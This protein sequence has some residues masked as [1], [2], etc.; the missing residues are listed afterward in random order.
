MKN[1][2]YILSDAKS[3]GK[4]LVALGLLEHL[5]KHAQR[6]I[7]F[8]PISKKKD[9]LTE[10]LQSYFSFDEADEALYG[11]VLDE[12]LPLLQQG[13][14]RELYALIFDKF[15][16]LEARYDHIIIIGTD[17][18]F[19]T[20][21]L[22]F[23]LNAALAN[24]LNAS[25]LALLN[26]FELEI[27]ALKERQRALL[28][29]L[30]AQHCS[31]KGV[32]INQIDESHIEAYQQAFNL[33]A[34]HSETTYVLPYSTVLA[35]MSVRDVVNA[36]GAKQWYAQEDDL[37]RSINH[38][39]IASMQLS[40]YLD[41]IEQDD[42]VIVSA[43][44]GD[45]IV[46]TVAASISANY[47]QIACML[48]TTQKN[49]SRQTVQLIEGIASYNICVVGIDCGTYEASMRLNSVKARLHS[50]NSR[51]VSAALGLFEKY[52]DADAL[53]SSL[54]ARRPI[55]TP[56]MFEYEL[57]QH[58]K[59]DKQRIVLPEG[60]D[61][62]ILRAAE[63]LL[64]RDVVDITILG[65]ID[66]IMAL[67]QKIGVSIAGA[68]IIDPQTSTLLS[69]Y[70]Q[71]YYALRKHKGV[72]LE[73]AHDTMLDVSYFGTMMVHLGDADGMVSGA[74]HTTQHTIRPAFEFI[75]MRQEVS[76]VSSSFLMC[77][78]ERVLLFADCA[79][80]PEP[81]ASELADIAIASAQTAE[82]FGISP[83][84]AML[85]YSTGD[86]GKGSEVDKVREATRLAKERQNALMIDGPIQFDAAFDEKIGKKKLPNS[87]VA[88]E[89][90]VFIF[91][92][93]NTGNNTYKAVQ[94]SS[95]AVAIGPILQGLR[96]PVNDLSR[97]CTVAD[98]VNTV[99]ITAIQS[100]R[101]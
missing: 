53:L 90:T 52:I 35:Q 92:D 61:E 44:R 88:G 33:E 95:G 38:F 93:L 59:K 78:P 98:I 32:V 89:A 71:E 4:S 64:L 19:S 99:A 75:K 67:A 70:A 55:M 36:L 65:N 68:Q 97:G 79:V 56:S 10:L 60:D 6:V 25:V 62:R 9:A 13:N 77:M 85:S 91:P 83:R 76:L 46:G 43:D 100:Q 3:S 12:A 18:A 41:V 51:K 8:R 96:K 28:Q 29:T 23:S 24:H 48:L 27:T 34:S 73:L 80:V 58:A 49:L 5:H 14:E 20:Q 54:S 47:P 66:A 7:C 81:N 31:V 63:I 2:L 17:F 22:E 39:K 86:S 87:N 84:I 72:T 11:V 94:R 16:A 21:E 74:A 40:N 37:N 45:I 1:H 57:I 42:M 101:Q 30:K 50:Y 69:T 15:K 26:G 82:M